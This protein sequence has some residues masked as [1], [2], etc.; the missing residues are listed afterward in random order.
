VRQSDCAMESQQHVFLILN[1][2]TVYLVPKQGRE[3][4]LIFLRISLGVVAEQYAAVTG[5]FGPPNARGFR[6]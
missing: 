3:K 2:S 6:Y 5:R 1:I 4:A